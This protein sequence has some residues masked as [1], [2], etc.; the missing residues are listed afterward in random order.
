MKR[1]PKCDTVKALGAFRVRATGTPQS[2]CKACD[3]VRA[4]A[5]AAKNKERAAAHTANYQRKN[6]EALNA[7]ARRARAADPASARAAV[8]KWRAANGETAA[9]AARAWYYANP[10]RARAQEAK[11]RAVKL[12]AVAG[13]ADH[14]QIARIY[15]SAKEL[16]E[17][18]IDVHVDHVFPLRGRTVCGL[19]THDNLQILPAKANIAK[20]NILHEVA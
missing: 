17:C 11:R 3:N 10:V 4:A 14:E 5:W 20:G 15:A 9:A 2:H 6:R 13:W 19:H 16:R 8:A 12:Q 18:G 7:S 1:C